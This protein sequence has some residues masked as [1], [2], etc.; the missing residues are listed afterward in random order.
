MGRE[1]V[2]ALSMVG[3]LS[4]YIQLCTLERVGTSAPTAIANQRPI[5]DLFQLPGR[6]VGQRLPDRW[7]SGRHTA[8]MI[9]SGVPSNRD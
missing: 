2:V 3:T 1:F 5:D 9:A 7:R 4:H 8:W 6:P